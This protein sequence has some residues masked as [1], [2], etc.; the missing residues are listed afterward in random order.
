MK[1][2]KDMTT[3]I[4]IIR[5]LLIP[6]LIMVLFLA[7][8]SSCEYDDLPPKTDDSSTGYKLPKRTVPTAADLELQS[9]LKKEYNDAI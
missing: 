9:Q 8:F 7:I 6:S 5:R 1:T 2:V 4:N 3:H